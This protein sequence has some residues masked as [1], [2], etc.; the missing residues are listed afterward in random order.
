MRP[1]ILT[2]VFALL[3][4]SGS[5]GFAESE[6]AAGYRLFARDL[7]E[8]SVHGEPDMTVTRRVDAGGFVSLPLIDP[9]RVLGLTLEEAQQRIAETY[10]T[11]EIFIRP[12]IGMVVKEYASRE[13]S[14]IGQVRT[15]GRVTFPIEAQEM[16]IV[17]AVSQAGGFTRIGK[18]DAVRVTRPS[19]SGGE[20]TF[21]VDVERMI[22]GQGAAGFQV[23]PGDVIFVPERVF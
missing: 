11:S 15:P 9:V 1:A 5:A 7:V 23:Q 17:E 18:A 2:S 12:Q 6:P 22:N 13:I 16:S 8:V 3:L 4:A 19:A 10:R 20:E 21:T 14:V